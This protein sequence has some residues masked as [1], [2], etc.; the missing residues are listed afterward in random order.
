MATYKTFVRSAFLQTGQAQRDFYV[1]TPIKITDLQ[2]C[3]WLL[4]T[5]SYGLLI[6]N[7]KLQVLLDQMLHDI[8]FLSTSALVQLFYLKSECGVVTVT[9]ANFLLCSDAQV[10][11]DVI[12]A[13]KNRFT[14]G[15]VVH[16][17][18]TLRFFGLNTIQYDDYSVTIDGDDKLNGFSMAHITRVQRRP[19][20][21][22]FTTVKQ[23]IFSSI[24]SSFEW[25]GITASSFCAKVFSLYQQEAPSATI[26]TLRNQ[27]FRLVQLQKVIRSSP[28][29]ALLMT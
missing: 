7:A 21:K 29:A 15:T 2:H 28:T 24:N 27:L 17:P 5:A 26:S 16:G 12:H 9:L 19:L 10:V 20:T 8:G 18:S 3:L 25:L 6:A 4:L 22:T 13:I 1:V 11:D 23:K 14:L